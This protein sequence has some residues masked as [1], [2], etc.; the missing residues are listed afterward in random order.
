MKI[1]KDYLEYA[2][3]AILLLLV[4][5]FTTGF[6]GNT[7]GYNLVVIQNRDPNSMNPTYVQGDIFV[8]KKMAPDQINLGD[9]IVYKNSRNELII[10]RVILIKII[11]GEYFYVV[12]GDNPIT[13]YRPDID[14]NGFFISYNQILGVTKYRVPMVG[15]I[16]L[17]MQKN[18]S[19][20]IM[21]YFLAAIAG[22]AI[23]F[24][25]EEEKQEEE[26]FVDISSSQIR[27]YFSEK[28]SSILNAIPNPKN[29]K[30]I[31][32]FNIIRFVTI[33]TIVVLLT[34]TYFNPGFFYSDGMD[35]STGF[36]ALK[37]ETET[38]RISNETI[39]GQLVTVVFYQLLVQLYDEGKFL[40]S[41][42]SFSVDVYNQ[43]NE[44]VS[45]TIWNQKG[46]ITGLF[47]VGASIIFETSKYGN[48]TQEMLVF[49]T[50]K[51]NK[52]FSTMETKGSTNFTYVPPT[53]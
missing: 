21:I 2:L 24:W 36:V 22:L 3:I 30:T 4:I 53:Q 9:V 51:I 42:K 38:R 1:K 44:I 14:I 15:H 19:I 11:E 16:S 43:D 33:F 8:I 40:Q 17:A 39:N 48:S 29:P 41:I 20:Q 45:H 23:I 18:P 10:H 13:N 25:P 32:K 5:S 12:K 46:K 47:T 49:V 28:F 7:L 35:H 27:K 26:E 37:V 50:L 6:L 31:S 34:L 52:G